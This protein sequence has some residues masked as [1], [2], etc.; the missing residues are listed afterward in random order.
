MRTLHSRGTVAARIARLGM[1][2]TG[3][4]AAIGLGF[5]GHDAAA[6]SLDTTGSL[7]HP[8]AGHTA[9]LVDGKVLITGGTAVA[10]VYNPTTGRFSSVGN[11]REARVGH[12]ATRLARR[13]G[14][15]HRRGP[16]VRIQDSGSL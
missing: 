6:Q 9:T 15:P 10:E 13:A 16:T 1:A 11:M 4:V 5:V 14:S 3:Y 7:I 8:R 12:T 2:V